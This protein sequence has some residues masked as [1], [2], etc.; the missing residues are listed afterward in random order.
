MDAQ[1]LY[2]LLHQAWHQGLLEA[3]PRSYS[4][5]F[6]Y[7]RRCIAIETSDNEGPLQIGFALGRLS[8]GCETVPT[9]Y[10]DDLGRHQIVYWRHLDWNDETMEEV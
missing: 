1:R 5:R 3:H 10:V 9:T 8:E 6:M 2:D 7:S 4:G